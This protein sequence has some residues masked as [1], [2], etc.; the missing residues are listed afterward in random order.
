MADD[1]VQLD[2]NSPV[3]QRDLFALGKQE[4]TA[5]LSTLKRM[6]AMTWRQVYA[7]S[8]LKWETPSIPARDPRTAF[9]QLPD[10]PVLPG[11]DLSRRRLAADPQS[12]SRSR[13]HLPVGPPAQRAGAFPLI[14]P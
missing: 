5:L 12:A 6:R 10:Q 7:D 1:T 8:G 4:Q 9:V 3:F 2:L 14:L 13:F 11:R